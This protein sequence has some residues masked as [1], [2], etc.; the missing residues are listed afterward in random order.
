MNILNE[1]VVSDKQNVDAFYHTWPEDFTP[2][3]IGVRYK[4]GEVI[5]TIIL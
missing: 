5:Q 4:T 3:F 2:V 1:E